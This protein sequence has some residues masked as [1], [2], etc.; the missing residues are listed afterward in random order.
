MPPDVTADVDVVRK[1]VVAKR[2]TRAGMCTRSS[3]CV[4][5]RSELGVHRGYRDTIPIN[6]IGGCYGR[7]CPLRARSIRC[8]SRHE[9]SGKRWRYRGNRR[10]DLA[11]C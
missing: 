9:Q 1:L 10:R 7:E 8:V 6:I 4:P 5:M 11:Y 2:R 3:A